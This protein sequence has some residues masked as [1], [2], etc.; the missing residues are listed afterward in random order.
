MYLT[1]EQA[2]SLIKPKIYK[3]THYYQ[4]FI[5]DLIDKNEL[6]EVNPDLFF[7][8]ENGEYIKADNVLAKRLV[9][10]QSVNEYVRKKRTHYEKY[11][12]NEKPG[13]S[14]KIVFSDNKTMRFDSFD[15][16]M[17]YFGI[18]RNIIRKS[19]AKNKTVEI[20]VRPDRLIELGIDTDPTESAGITT[21]ED[22]SEFVRFY[23]IE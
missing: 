21:Y 8:N 4:L 6:I 19:I 12:R 14:I 18:S 23:K 1:F 13:T 16:A 15:Q 22:I 3:N 2:F 11:G 7:C 10:A 9:T 17:N 20:P 5:R